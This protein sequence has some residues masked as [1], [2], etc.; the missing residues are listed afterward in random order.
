[1]M[2]KFL[3]CGVLSLAATLPGH[4]ATEYT[5]EQ[6]REMVASGNVPAQADAQQETKAVAFPECKAVVRSLVS[7]VQPDYPVRT[8]ADGPKMLSVK[9]WT[10][11]AAVVMSCSRDGRLVVQKALYR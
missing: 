4:A 5:P 10:N 1:M 6:L 11:D 9:L 2:K 3:T 7:D 8:L